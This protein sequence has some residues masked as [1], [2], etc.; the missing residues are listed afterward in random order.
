MNLSTDLYADSEVA[1]SDSDSLPSSG[2]D[3]HKPRME[4]EDPEDEYNFED[5][6]EGEEAAAI[7]QTLDP[8]AGDLEASDEEDEKQE[9]LERTAASGEGGE[10]ETPSTSGPK[11]MPP[12]FCSISNAARDKGSGYSVLGLFEG[13]G[14]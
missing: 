3:M 11:R 12:S 5:E 10:K 1:A 2:L 4:S 14:T 9:A 13:H 6:S 8:A 7:V